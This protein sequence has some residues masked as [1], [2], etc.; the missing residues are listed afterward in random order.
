[1]PDACQPE[2]KPDLRPCVRPVPLRNAMVAPPPSLHPR[3]QASSVLFGDPTSTAPSAFLASSA[4][5]GILP[6]GREPWISLVTV[7][8]NRRART[9]LRP[10][11]PPHHSPIPAVQGV[12]FGVEEHLGAV[13]QEQ[14]FG[15]RYLHGLGAAQ[16]HWSS[17]AFVPT[18]QPTRYRVDCKARYG[19]GGWPLPRR[20]LP[21]LVTTTLPGRFLHLVVRRH[22]ESGHIS[23]PV[24]GRD[25]S[26]MSNL[27]Q[28]SGRGRCVRNCA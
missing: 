17:L 3:Y 5:T 9:G 16:V 25:G 27:S 19:A 22:Y 2:F 20:D 1:M 26:T 15:A 14:D 4:R 28:P 7:M 23:S 18:H 10:R 12:A 21:P 11:V 8:T 6:R 24:V 13:P